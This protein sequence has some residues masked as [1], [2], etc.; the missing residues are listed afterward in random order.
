MIRVV[1][2]ST[3]YLPQDIIDRHNIRVVPLNVHFEDGRVFQEGIDLT[4]Q[5][6]YRMLAMCK[7]LPT[8]SQ[9]SP[10]LFQSVFEELTRTGDQVICTVLSTKMS[11]TYQSAIEARR[12]LPNADIVVIDSQMV[13]GGLAFLT[14]TAAEMAQDGCSMHEIVSRMEQMKEEVRIYFAVDTL[15]YL[16]K[17]GRIGTASAM[18]GT[19]LKV[20]PIL[21]VRD[22]IVQP[23]DKVRSRGRAVQRLVDEFVDYVADRQPAQ[24]ILMHAMAHED[25]A[26]LRSEL[27]NKLKC[28]RIICTEVGSIV[29]T[30]TGPGVIGGAVCPVHILDRTEML[31]NQEL[32]V[33]VPV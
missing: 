26:V 4:N 3:G 7:Q 16:Q 20:K 25:V 29:G 30:H 27:Q 31:C 2:D 23:V 22:G 21:T 28:S 12:N 33:P 24:V 9:P 8:T 17:G 10:A 1:T 18:L 14:L 13:A 11:G 32:A 15:E 5:E 19:L 6:F